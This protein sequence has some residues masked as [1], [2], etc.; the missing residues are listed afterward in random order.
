MFDYLKCA[1]VLETKLPVIHR[2]SGVVQHEEE[3]MQSWKYLTLQSNA[4]Q[5]NTPGGTM[6]TAQAIN[7]A[8]Q[9]NWELVTVLQVAPAVFDFIF[10]KPA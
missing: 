7:S 1:L 9:Q 5:I 2:V 10:K 6:P 3:I 8:G 4:G